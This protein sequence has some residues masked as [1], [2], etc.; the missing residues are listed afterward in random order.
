MH[1]HAVIP[2]AT[3]PNVEKFTPQE[4]LNVLITDLVEETRVLESIFNKG[5]DELS[6]QNMNDEDEL[7]SVFLVNEED[8]R[9]AFD[10]VG[11]GD[12]HE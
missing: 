9:S 5:A 11:E 7:I 4:I 8:F 1:N 10:L 3:K 6:S 2:T 12:S